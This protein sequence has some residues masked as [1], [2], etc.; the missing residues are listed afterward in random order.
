M[1]GA[2]LKHSLYP[3][4]R[5]KRALPTRGTVL[6]LGCGEGM[7]TNL[8]AGALPGA[9]FIGLD[10]EPE[11]IRIATQIASP[12]ALFE[13]ADISNCRI[14]GAAAVIFNDVLHHHPYDRQIDL[15][16]I[17]CEALDDDGVLI[18]KE[19]DAR[20]GPD[21]KWTRFWDS[22]LYAADTLHFRTA[23]DWQ[24]TLRNAGLRLLDTY[25]FRHPWPASRTILVATKRPKLPRSSVVAA[26]RE[27]S[28]GRARVLVTGATGFV[29]E[30][31]VRELLRSGV[32]GR[33]ADV[34][35]IA[36]DPSLL[37]ADIRTDPSVAVIP[38]DLVDIDRVADRV[39]Q[40]E[41][42]FHLAAR[43]DFFARQEVVEANTEP[44]RKLLG[45]LS[46]D[47]VK[48]FVYTSTMGAVDRA[49]ADP[50]T[51][52]LD[53]DALA[54]PVSF[55][56][57]SKLEGE[58]LVRESG[59]AFTI[60]RIPWCYGPG[61]SPTHHVRALYE[62]VA[63]GGL[64]F[65]FDWPGRVSIIEVGEAARML[66]AVAGD[67]RTANELYFLTDGEP[68]TF[69]ALF[70]A[71]GRLSGRRAGHVKLPV[72]LLA[73]A[74]WLRRWAP[75]QLRCLYMDVLAAS[76]SKLVATG[77]RPAARRLGFLLPLARYIQLE[78]W[79]SRHRS[80]VLITGGAGGIGLALAR[81]CY[82]RGYSLTL[83]DSDD[84]R[85]QQAAH[86]LDAR[87]T[88]VDL[89][90][91]AACRRF[92]N[93]LEADGDDIEIAV[94]NAGIGARGE[95]TAVCH[96]R[97]LDMIRVN[98][99]APVLISRALVPQFLMKG[100][101]TIVN[102]ASSAAFQP[103]P[104]MAVYAAS[105]AFMLSFSEALAGELRWAGT[106][107]VSVITVSPSGTAT[108]FQ[109]FAG[110]KESTGL[111]DPDC[112][113]ARIAA[114]FDGGSRTIVIGMTGRLMSLAARALSGNT[115]AGLWAY[116]MRKHR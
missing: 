60:I 101:G 94:N 68:I 107:Q 110:V 54:H 93:D 18:L 45:V 22:R 97:H 104:Y 2:L 72:A 13:V 99:M 83:V 28:G 106:G 88:V 8:L 63:A 100:S 114:A 20:D 113:A 102:I 26:P 70:A 112:V 108:G 31:L 85:L 24:H 16:A 4:A 81:H 78:R 53:E 49:P 51:I 50:C 10:R 105:K 38:V 90:D 64:A 43:V 59:L 36:R 76:N 79:P 55:Y 61:M 48:R 21:V 115:R 73:P 29:G 44:T 7:L 65:K 40:S 6:D 75:F 95:Y 39:R 19:V 67:A 32:A 96:E 42:V 71:M 66:C 17:A 41:F 33:T 34:T 5:L 12:N 62:R 82:A 27:A 91:E 87:A 25:V 103:L 111:L 3:I 11:R 98:C 77:H 14:R 23:Q 1:A 35:V 52:E 15:L 80:R 30:H 58:R 56:G 92:A 116:L 37:A 57:R 89:A 46:K 9:R 69:G 86:Q 47:C 84:G 74:V 109:R